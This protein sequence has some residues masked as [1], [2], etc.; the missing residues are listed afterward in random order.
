MT[1]ERVIDCEG[2]PA[3]NQSVDPLTIS[4]WHKGEPQRR[5]VAAARI[6]AG[7]LWVAET[8]KGE[9]ALWRELMPVWASY[10]RTWLVVELTGEQVVCVAGERALFA[11]ND[12]GLQLCVRQGEGSLH[13]YEERSRTLARFHSNR[14]W[15]WLEDWEAAYHRWLVVPGALTVAPESYFTALYAFDPLDLSRP[16]LRPSLLAE[17]QA[18][19]E[20]RLPRTRDGV[21]VE[22]CR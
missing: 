20:I 15:A 17:R 21:R 22:M 2:L 1:L 5:Q 12:R 11:G 19:N 3:D 4:F 16:R 7:Q 8:P 18:A 13:R 14:D 6:G 9:F 10:D